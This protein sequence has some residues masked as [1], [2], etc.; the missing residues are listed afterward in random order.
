MNRLADRQRCTESTKWPEPSH[1]GIQSGQIKTGDQ[2]LA[3]INEKDRADIEKNH[4]ATHLLHQALKDVLGTHVNQAGS[5]VSRT[6]SDLISHTL[7]K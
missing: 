4:T 3:K 7:E 6:D 5:R 1:S 2:L